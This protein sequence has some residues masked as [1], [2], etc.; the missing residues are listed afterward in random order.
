[1]D[2]ISIDFKQGDEH[3]LAL[4][5]ERVGN[6]EVLGMN[7]KIIE[8]EDIQINRSGSPSKGFC[9]THLG[10]NSLQCPEEFRGFQIR[11]NF[12]YAVDEPILGSITKGLR[13]KEG[14]LC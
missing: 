10:F 11:L 2:E 13:F 12:Y 5:D 1:M 8:K 7:L 14:R 3:E 6:L 4:P 9:A